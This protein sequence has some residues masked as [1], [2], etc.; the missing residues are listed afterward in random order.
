MKKSK[1]GYE[2]AEN[3]VSSLECLLT[4]PPYHELYRLA[5]SPVQ[6]QNRGGNKEEDR[7]K[8]AKKGKT[9]TRA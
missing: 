4:V 2:K 7:L 3:L 8:E 1:K 5:W 9:G 6:D